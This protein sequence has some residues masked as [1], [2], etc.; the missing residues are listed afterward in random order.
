MPLYEFKCECGEEKE[1]LL[2]LQHSEQTCKCGK[3]MQRK[4]SLSRF[5]FKP[6]ARNMALDSINSKGG[7]FPEVNKHKSWV[8]KT[9]FEGV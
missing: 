3:V 2:P 6:Y 5:T 7:G 4:V 9:A 8:Q 1:I